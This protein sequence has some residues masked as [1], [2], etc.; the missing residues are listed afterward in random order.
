MELPRP[1]AHLSCNG[2][3]N[4]AGNHLSRLGSLQHIETDVCKTMVSKVAR[5]QNNVWT[6]KTHLSLR[7]TSRGVQALQMPTSNGATAR[8]L[9]DP[10]AWQPT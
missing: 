10:V 4:N 5:S 9:R 6:Q 2:A 7:V 1:A 8:T 3:L